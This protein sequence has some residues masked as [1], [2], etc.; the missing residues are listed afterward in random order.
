MAEFLLELFSEE[1][2][3]RMQAE[4]ASHLARLFRKAMGERGFDEAALACTTYVTPR[5]LTLVATSLPL[6]QPDTREERKGP[7][8]NAPA[9]AL[10]GFLRSTGMTREQLKVENDGKSEFFLA[11]I[12][13]K[14]SA[15]ASV[16][17][18]VITEIVKSF[19][20]PKSMRWAGRDYVWVRPLRGIVALLDGKL[21]NVTI[22]DV[23]SGNVTWGHRLMAPGAISVT[24][25]ADYREKLLAAKVMLDVEDRKREIIKG[26]KAEAARAGLIFRDDP[27]LLDEVAGLVEWPVVLTGGFEK[28]FLDVPAEVLVST[29]RKNQKYFALYDLDGKLANAFLVVAN[30]VADDGGKAIIAGN[31]RVVRARLSDARFFWEQDKKITLAE[32]LPQLDGIVFHAKLGTQGERVQRIEALA[33]HIAEKIGADPASARLAARL[34]K[35][36]LVSGTVGEFPEVQGTIG[37]YLAAH[38]KL[39]RNVADAISDH[40]R[41]VGQN[42]APPESRVAIAVA[43]ADKLDTLTGFFAIDEKPT[44]S[45]D[46]YALRR[47]ALGVIRILLTA[48]INLRLAELLGKSVAPDLVTFFVDRLKVVLRESGL[49]HDLL[50]AAFA[51]AGSDN[52]VQL[53]ARI[54]ALRDLL[55]TDDGKNLLAGYKRAANILRIEEKKDKRTYNGAVN[56]ALLNLP[57]EQAL[58]AALDHA[59]KH[60]ADAVK[61]EDFAAAMS[62]LAA[63]RAPVDAFFDK[64]IVND[65]DPALRENRL[66]L[67]ARIKLAAHEVA[68][69]SKIEG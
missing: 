11:V 39:G 45:K 7:R 26:A 42:D 68:D 60:A 25:F 19:P 18:D 31:E 35:A 69:F 54:D 24:G 28:E 3:A 33:G 49:R 5:R 65:P 41:P 36:D 8:T 56:P 38:E 2:P 12:E 55:A 61:R 44:G 17:A 21:V 37:G 14:G 4:A 63:L 22:G 43:L 47:A 57:Q 64:V 15:T 34:C 51:A 9:A 40:Y 53:G 6:Q 48:K 58:A 23:V 46:P 67:L 13:K 1:I 32:R 20:W 50:D 59:V 30:L 62:A 16:L 66:N 29:M 52:F 27:E 10:E